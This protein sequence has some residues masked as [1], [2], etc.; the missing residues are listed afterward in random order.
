LAGAKWGVTFCRDFMPGPN[1][2]ED[3]R[4]DIGRWREAAEKLLP[5]IRWERC[6]Y[7]EHR[8]TKN[9]FSIKPDGSIFMNPDAEI[10]EVLQ[11]KPT[12]NDRRTCQQFEVTHKPEKRYSYENNRRRL[13]DY[14]KELKLAEHF[15]KRSGHSSRDGKK[16]TSRNAIVT[17]AE[18]EK[19]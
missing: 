6:Y 4:K 3:K 10:C 9:M 12:S 16:E 11:R 5:N 14:I 2:G 8:N 15:R 13:P 18:F 7:C 17:K 1:F 19:R